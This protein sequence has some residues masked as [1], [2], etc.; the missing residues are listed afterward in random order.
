MNDYET[1]VERGLMAVAGRLADVNNILM[2]LAYA[3]LAAV[4][5]STMSAEAR[6]RYARIAAGILESEHKGEAAE[7]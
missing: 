6:S 7:G 1:S 4:Q 5:Q 2:A 3:Q